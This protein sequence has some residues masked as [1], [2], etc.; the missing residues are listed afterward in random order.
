MAGVIVEKTCGFPLFLCP[1]YAGYLSYF[2]HRRA[3]I[4]GLSFLGLSLKV[5]FSQQ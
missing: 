3:S 5:S 4:V 2:P 1:A